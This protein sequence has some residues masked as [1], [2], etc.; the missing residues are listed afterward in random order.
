MKN[1]VWVVAIAVVLLVMTGAM[2]WKW[3]SD[4]Y[5]Y[6]KEKGGKKKNKDGKDDGEDDGEDG[7]KKKGKKGK[8]DGGSDKPDKP[9]KKLAGWVCPEGYR[10]SG[11][12][13]PG[14]ECVNSSGK[15]SGT[16][17]KE[18][19]PSS[20]LDPG[21]DYCSKLSDDDKKKLAEKMT[22]N[23]RLGLTANQVKAKYAPKMECPELTGLLD[24]AC[25]NGYAL[26]SQTKQS[27]DKCAKPCPSEFLSRN[28]PCLSEDGTKCCNKKMENCVDRFTSHYRDRFQSNKTPKDP[29]GTD[30]SSDPALAGAPVSSGPSGKGTTLSDMFA[31]YKAK[32]TS[33][34]GKLCT[35]PCGKPCPGGYVPAIYAA[36][37]KCD[38]HGVC[39]PKW[40][41][42][43]DK[44]QQYCWSDQGTYKKGQAAWKK[45]C[46]SSASPPPVRAVPV[47]GGT[48]KVPPALSKMMMKEQRTASCYLGSNKVAQ[49]DVTMEFEAG[50]PPSEGEWNSMMKKSC[51]VKPECQGRCELTATGNPSGPAVQLFSQGGFSGGSV[52]IDPSDSKIDGPMRVAN[53]WGINRDD[54]S[55]IIVADGYGALINDRHGADILQ[56][57]NWDLGPGRYDFAGG[58]WDNVTDDIRIYRR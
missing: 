17:F 58:G 50:A 51:N 14:H 8:D 16:V 53:D 44:K 42:Y 30:S 6:E 52:N 38:N 23:C 45:P 56:H 40:A 48:M 39:C 29:K 28:K 49:A 4:E 18:A 33:S 46:D 27:T 21:S 31:A 37:G 10:W 41:K 35:S 22:K 20:K 25:K 3:N 5:D 7:G 11:K 47:A 55:S 24:Q 19:K 9:A 15:E 13:D 1:A 43:L 34:S 26:S 36:S 54:L 32:N 2:A 57:S 12:R